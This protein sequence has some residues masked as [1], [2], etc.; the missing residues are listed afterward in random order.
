MNPN[1]H[2][3]RRYALFL[4]FDSVAKPGHLPVNRHGRPNRSLRGVLQCDGGSKKSHNPVTGHLV[5]RALIVVDLVNED[6]VNLVHHLIGFLSAESLRETGK[7]LHV[8]EHHRDQLTLTLYSVLLGQD[9][10]GEI[11]GKV[12]LNFY[13]LLIKGEFFGSW[14]GREAEVKA[15][16]TT[17]FVPGKAFRAAVRADLG[18]L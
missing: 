2:F 11:F 13:Q 1:P 14:L 15:T 10:L 8:A 17:K 5:D 3:E 18:K 7:S 16:F 9:L 12:S 6:L 4:S